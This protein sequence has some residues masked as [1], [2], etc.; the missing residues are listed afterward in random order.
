MD[1][2]G[3]RELSGFRA[4]AAGPG[5]A[6]SAASEQPEEP[7]AAAAAE[8]TEKINGV[9]SHET[10][11]PPY[12]PFHRLPKWEPAGRWMH[13]RPQLTWPD[14]MISARFAPHLLRGLL[15]V[16]VLVGQITTG[17]DLR[18]HLAVSVSR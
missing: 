3:A 17:G 15:A 12:S 11:L 6:E 1:Q 8:T 9:W 16:S 10:V 18:R 4:P 2:A 13:D 5:P 14:S 7:S